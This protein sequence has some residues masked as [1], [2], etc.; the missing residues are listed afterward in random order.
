M[1]RIKKIMVKITGK[2]QLLGVI[3]DPVEHSLS[4][5][6]H[7][8][9][10]TALGLDFVYLPLP[11]KVKGLKAALEGFEAIGVVGF[12]VTIPHKQAIIPLL[13][14][15][16]PKAKLVGAVN[17]VWWTEAGWSGTNTDVTGFIAPLQKLRN[18][19]G[20]TPIVLG[21][22]GAARA[23]VVGCA[24]LGCEEVHVVG[25]NGEKL[26]QFQESWQGTPLENKVIVHFREDLPNLLPNANLLINTTPVG[27]FPKID[28]LPVNTEMM[29]KINQSAIAYDLIYN[30]RPTKFLQIAQQQGLQ[31]I[32]GT[33]MLIEQGAAAL[34]I[35]LQ[36]PAPNDIMRSALLTALSINKGKT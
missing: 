4:P 33:E 3:G 20:V 25:R 18:Q 29:E 9:A 12:N 19:S 27:M 17:T 5:T 14:E 7:N 30:P 26:R 23:V 8:A 13:A 31:T 35:W 32:D 1:S 15:V 22:G 24:E 11:V 34:E 6:M 2:T 10:L 28:A 21:N 36:Q 16:T